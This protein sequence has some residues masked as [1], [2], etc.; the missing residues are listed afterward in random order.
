M[1]NKKYFLLKGRLVPFI[2]GAKSNTPP[3][4][5]E[6]PNSLFSTDIFYGTLALGEGPV[7]RINPNGPQD[8]EFNEGSIDD[9]IKLDGDGTVNTDLLYTVSSS[10]A[11]TSAGIPSSLLK[12]FI[13]AVTTPQF[14]A[15]PINLKKGNLDGIPPVFLTQ[16]TSGSAWDLLSFNFV[17]GSLLRMDDAGNILAYSLTVKITI[18]DYTGSTILTKE[19]GTPLIIEREISGKTNNNYKFNIHVLIPPNARSTNG[20]KFKVEKANDD[21]ASSKIQES[22][23]FVGWEEVK[24]SRNSYPRTALLGVA[25]KAQGEYTGG[26]PTITSL[27]K[28]LIIKVPSNYNQPTLDTGE[29]DWRELETP[30]SGANSYTTC[31]YNLEKTGTGTLLTEANPIIYVGAWDGTFVYKWTQ[32]PVWVLYDLLT[33]VS[34]GL[35][36]PEEHIDKFKFYKV[37]QYCDAVEPKTGRFIG[38]SGFSDGTFRYKPRGKFT[39]IRQNQLGLESGTAVI[40]RRFVCNV[41]INTQKQVMDI[42]NQITGVFRGILFYNAGKVSLNVD[43]PDEVPVAVY[44]ETNILK[45]TLSITGIKESEILTGVE[46]SYS[47]PKNHYRRELVRVDDPDALTDLNSIE[48]TKSFDLAACDRRSQ[49]MRFGQYLLA[50]NKYVRRRVSFKTQAEGMTSTIGDVI[51]VS[52]RVG[53]IAWGYG[54]RVFANASTSSANII[55]E[56]FTSPAITGPVI[57]GNT[58]PIALRVINRE[59][60]RV[61]LYLCQNTFAS[62]SSSNVNAGIDIIEL[63]INKIYKPQTKSFVAIGNFMA[64]ALPVKGDIWSLGEVDPSNYYTNTNDKLFKI[65]NVERDTEEVVSIVA[66]E[67]VSNVYTDSDSLINYVPTRYQDTANPL[68]PPPAPSLTV[69]PRPIRQLGGSVKYDLEIN[70]FTDTTGYPTFIKTELQIAKPS[71]IITI[72]GI[73]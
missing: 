28:G 64:N 42:I 54:G 24:F 73:S 2:A 55:L 38:V 27:I 26:V 46:V 72:Q 5:I 49:A 16:N 48:N 68:I 14:L 41:S 15:A 19:D 43:L 66:T 21:S 39:S 60:D 59:T 9:L 53:G 51:A 30:T 56:H 58:K 63:T 70:A 45:N 10:G 20:Y 34:Y 6:T 65:T 31:G 37:A 4:P 36:I 11:S 25:L 17:I 29:I 32:N 33:N 71:E 52:Q 7:Y 47:E 13:G 57:T 62:V 1:Y 8:I 69:I 50:S 61:E 3:P 40:E 44:N 35:G 12:R 23:T 18:Y 22:I 67:Y